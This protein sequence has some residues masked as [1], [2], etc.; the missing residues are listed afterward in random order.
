MYMRICLLSSV[1]SCQN[2]FGALP[3]AP[4][5]LCNGPAAGLTAHSRSP[6]AL[7]RPRACEKASGL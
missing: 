7:N 6:A 5:G 3:L 4:P 2:I 1:S